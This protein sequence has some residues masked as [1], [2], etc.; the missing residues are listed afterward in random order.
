M[1]NNLNQVI[2]ISVFPFAGSD[3]SFAPR[4]SKVDLLNVSATVNSTAKFKCLQT[5]SEAG[6]N[7]LQF[8]WIKWHNIPSVV[9]ELDIDYGNFTV[10]HSNSKYL[11]E[12]NTEEDLFVSYLSIHNVTQ[13]DIGLYSCIVCNHY[14]RD[15]SSVFL[16][17]NTTSHPGWLKNMQ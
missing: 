12:P 16:G 5:K 10:I 1:H 14:G 2:T 4:I 15:Y 8:D 17:L 3:N 11:I 6:L 9:S 7:A 13:A